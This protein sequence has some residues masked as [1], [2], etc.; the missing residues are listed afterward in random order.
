VTYEV[1]FLPDVTLSASSVQIC[2]GEEIELQLEVTGT[3][4]PIVT[5]SPAE[6]LSCTD[7]LNPVASPDQTTVYTVTTVGCGGVLVEIEVTVEIVPLPGLTVTEDQTIDLGQTV[8]VQGTNNVPTIPINWYDGDSGDP[9]CS[10]CPNLVQQPK[11]A[12]VYHF[13]ASAVNSL[14]CS[15]EDTVTVTVID[16][17]ELEKIEAANAFT[18]NNDGFNDYFE[19]RNSGISSIGLVQIFNRWGEI[20]FE[21]QDLNI[22][23][24]G[25]F[26]GEPV[27]PGVYM[28]I[29]QGDC[30]NLE[31][32]QLAGNVTVIR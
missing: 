20:V 21:T 32:F 29:I 24:D 11:K 13:I 14:G 18:P 25:M 23:W 1:T 26:R 30:V 10:D 12:G 8:T 31:S 28:Y 15:E 6:G 17:C 16:P 2:E 9:L 27:N 5:W 7:C 22:K 4:E 3:D 19:I